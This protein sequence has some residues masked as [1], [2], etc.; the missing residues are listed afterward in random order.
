MPVIALSNGSRAA[1][2]ALFAGAGLRGHVAQILSVE[3][4]GLFKPC[5]DI[6]LHAA[7]AAGLPPARLMM[8]ATHAW[9][10]HGAKSAGLATGF[11]ARGQT[12]PDT[13]A[14]PD[15]IGADLADLIGTVIALPAR[16]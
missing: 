8:V 1:T 10:L 4:I 5:R 15:V 9:D 3:D 6:Y 2:E 12:Y 7:S 13:M 14:A 11:I 16:A